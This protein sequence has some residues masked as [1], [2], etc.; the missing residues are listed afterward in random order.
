MNRRHYSQTAN[1]LSSKLIQPL[2]ERSVKDRYMLQHPLQEETFLSK[3][4]AY[5]Y[6]QDKV[7]KSQSVYET[8]LHYTNLNVPYVIQW[9][10]S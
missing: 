6:Y 2:H 3:G 4:Y 8:F 10:E 1:Y 9:M 5:D 7:M